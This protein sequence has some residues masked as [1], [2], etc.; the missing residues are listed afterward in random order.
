MKAF[1]R[2]ILTAGIAVLAGTAVP[3]LAADGGGHTFGVID[4][5]KVM[6]KTDAAKDIF[7]QLEAKRKEYQSQIAK[8]ED[9]LRAAEQEIIKQKD[10]LSKDE[11]DKKRAGFEEKVIQGQKLVQDRKRTLD[12]AF[13]SA[14]GNLRREAAKI[15][16][17]AAKEKQ[18]SAVFTQDAVMMSTPDLDITDIVIERM[19]KTVKKISID[20]AASGTSDDAP[21]KAKSK[22]K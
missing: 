8:E 22:K 14:V 19:N 7:S 4:M 20:W 15:V 2:I 3:A 6:Q 16:A 9:A 12:Q 21:P 17:E 18:F 1:K 5:T 10:S 13:N 11:F